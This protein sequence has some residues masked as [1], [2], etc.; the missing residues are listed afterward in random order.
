MRTPRALTA[1]VAAGL[2]VV[3][4]AWFMLLYRPKGAEISDVKDQTEVAEAEEQSLRATLAQL[5]GIDEAR[6]EEEAEVRR[7]TAAVPPQP[8][9]ASFILTVHDAASRADLAFLAISPSF[10]TREG[11]AEAST[12]ATTIDLEGN[13]FNIVDFLGR[14]EDLERTAVVD[15][16][17]LTATGSDGEGGEGGEA[18]A[19][20]AFGAPIASVTMAAPA[21][22]TTT[23]TTAVAAAPDRRRAGIFLL[24]HQAVTRVP[25]RL[26]RVSLQAR[27]FTTAP[28]ASAEGGEEETTTTTTTA[29][30]EGGG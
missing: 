27:I 21:T 16:V 30:G 10:P 6:P 3:V 18:S 25:N 7:L 11:G 19:A 26:L 29:P 4:V 28:A 15:A 20:T 12:I 23:T 9:L 22:T 1:A 2:A 14:L 8:E 5:E 24:P 17:S 13:F